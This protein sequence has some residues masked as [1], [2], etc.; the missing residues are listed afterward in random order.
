MKEVLKDSYMTSVK[1]GWTDDIEQVLAILKVLP[2]KAGK[3]TK[4]VVP[5][6]QAIDKFIVHCEVSIN[7]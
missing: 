2:A 3:H 1:T 7:L 5:F 6:T 4:S